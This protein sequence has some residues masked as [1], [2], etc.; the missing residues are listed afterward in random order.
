MFVEPIQVVAGV[1]R[2]R[3]GD[4]VSVL[5]ETSF[6]DLVGY[7][8]LDFP[9]HVHDVQTK[10]CGRNVKLAGVRPLE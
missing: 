4:L 5:V 9:A 7:V 1:Y 3:V 8:A 10:D 6:E 2:L